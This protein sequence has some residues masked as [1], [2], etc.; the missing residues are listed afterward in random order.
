MKPIPKKTWR[1]ILKI[2]LIVLG[3]YLLLMVGLSIYIFSSKERLVNFL[4]SKMKESILGEMKIGNADVTVWRSFPNIGIQLNNLTISDSVYHRQFLN[5]KQITAKIGLF[6]LLGAKT[7]INSVE[8]DNAVIHVFTDAKGY[9]NSYVLKPQNKSTKKDKKPVVIN[10]LELVNVTAI[11][12]NFIK[13]KRYQVTIKNADVDMSLSGS[14]YHID[15]DEDAFIRGLGF[16]MAKGYW[17]ENQRLQ[18]DF[19][20]EFDTSGKILSFDET[21]IKIQGQ[22][23]KIK[24]AFYLRQPD[25]HFRVDASTEDIPYA[26]AMAILK[27]TTSA[28]IAKLKLTKGLTATITIDGPLA[29]KTTPLVKVNFN[30]TGNEMQTPVL[31]F[32]DCSFKG[33]YINQANNQL[34]KSDDN[35]RIIISSFTSSWGDIKLQAQNIAVTNL[36]KP[37]IQFE[38]Y[39]ECTLPQLDEQ[40]STETIH[41][42]DGNAK[43]YLSY[44][45]PLIADASL[46][47]QLN[48]KIQIINGKIVYVPRSLTFSQCN[49]DVALTG[50]N[51]SMNN[52]QCNLNTNHFVVNVNGENLNRI[53]D[54]I[55]GK[56]SIT[57]DVFSPEVNLGDFKGLFAKR[58]AAKVAAKKG[59]LVNAATSIDN[60]VENGNLYVNLKA[61]KVTLHNF[62]AS[63]VVANIDFEEDD[64]EVKKAALQ[65]A[66]GSFNLTAKVHQA[67]D[68]YK[69]GSMK[70]NLQNI[71]V[72][73]MFYGFDNFGQT[74]ITSDNIKGIMN[75]NANITSN[76]D[77]KGKLDLSSMNGDMF[78]SLKKG[79]LINNESIQS[80]QKYA[81][82]NR[83][84]KNIEFA[85]LKDTFII[86]N[87]DIYIE[88]M[89]IQSSAITMYIEG[90]YSFAD[91]T[92]ISI[93]VPLSTLTS[94][95]DE[96]FK[97]I[98]KKRAKNPGA[99][100][101]LRA[102]DKD[103]KVK[104]GLDLFKK[105]RK[106]KYDK[107]LDDAK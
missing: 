60:A 79:A 7:N 71:N 14:K 52:F 59:G 105:L 21:K 45:G 30:T 29:Y 78:F 95:P 55:N 26:A 96:D 65:F 80:I 90:V 82:K 38:F 63:N 47:D 84:L 24:G 100:I 77:S 1:R 92:D 58:A 15:V 51:L 36:I 97:K 34:P 19:H 17:L 5:A 62:L 2:S 33:S 22:P 88:R 41:F 53:S 11:S 75:S 56:A 8:V 87:G 98:D 9:S 44:N 101:Y 72:K 66:D 39:S 32:T 94:K 28:K 23:F 16:N 13:N 73:K 103:G 43:L 6:D 49:G 12:E 69:T 10:N 93:Q 67:N 3:V 74:S 83:D 4:T 107:V 106:D 102:K 40:L 99:S 27:P 76:F 81:F 18:G 70:M 54:K 91:R 50:N 61:N 68:A 89:P 20:L 31:N 48:A 35:S 85:E 86:K 46:L 25:A 64:W 37:V 42:T 57:C 104:I